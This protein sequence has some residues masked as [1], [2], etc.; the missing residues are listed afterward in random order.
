M[1]I[2]HFRMQSYEIIRYKPSA[3]KEKVEKYHLYFL[4]VSDKEYGMKNRNVVK[5]GRK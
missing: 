1:H 5:S 2:W 3:C 4:K